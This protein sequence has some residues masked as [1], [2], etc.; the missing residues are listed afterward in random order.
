MKLFHIWGLTN[1]LALSYKCCYPMSCTFLES[2]G[3]CGWVCVRV[4]G[5]RIL[6]AYDYTLR[7]P[8]PRGYYFL[9]SS[10]GCHNYR[11]DQ[12]LAPG[13]L[14]IPS[15]KWL[16]LMSTGF[17]MIRIPVARSWPLLAEIL[18][19]QDF[20]LEC[21]QMSVL[22]LRGGLEFLCIL[23]FWA[24]TYCFQWAS[25]LVPTV[26]KWHIVQLLWNIVCHN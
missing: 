4:F 22:F 6:L 24:L 10:T 1:K 3:V 12:G 17:R 23:L 20:L 18:I 13:G 25:C 8:L 5:I 26:S 9:P 14:C 16:E 7:T 21:R 15:F 19:S 2:P 11:L